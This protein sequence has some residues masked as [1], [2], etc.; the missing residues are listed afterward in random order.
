[1][2]VVDVVL[3]V[4]AVLFAITGWRRGLV[5]G[6]LVTRRFSDWRRGWPVARAEGSRLVGR[7]FSQG[8][9][10]TSSS[11]SCALASDRRWLAWSDAGL[12]G[13][14]TWGP[15]VQA[16]QRRRCTPF[17]LHHAAGGLVPCRRSTPRATRA[18]LARDVQ[19]VAGARRVRRA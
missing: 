19:T 8:A 5:Y 9:R 14:V 1:M 13:A 6:V 2:S 17:G 7:R 3:L 12:Q 15:L 18:A 16:Q 10:R 11:C 4:A